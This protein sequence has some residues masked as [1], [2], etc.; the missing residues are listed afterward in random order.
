MVT[1]EEVADLIK[2]LESNRIKRTMSTNNTNKFAEAVCAFANDFPNTGMSGNN[3]VLFNLKHEGKRQGEGI[4]FH[5]KLFY[6]R[7]VL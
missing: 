7:N 2:R 6:A 5:F 1:Q 4:V 3:R